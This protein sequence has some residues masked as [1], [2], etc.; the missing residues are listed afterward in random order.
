MKQSVE[1]TDKEYRE[2]LEWKKTQ[3]PAT[4]KHL[5]EL[6]AMKGFQ[7][8][9][10]FRVDDSDWTLVIC[11]NKY[12]YQGYEEIGFLVIGDEIYRSNKV[13]SSRGSV[14]LN[15]PVN[16]VDYVLLM[17]TGCPLETRFYVEGAKDYIEC[18]ELDIMELFEIF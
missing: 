17:K 9:T 16:G 8:K 11:K 10:A 4:E 18:R 7:F 6:K 15:I 3:V 13:K 1:M 2:F 5:A 14:T 12:L